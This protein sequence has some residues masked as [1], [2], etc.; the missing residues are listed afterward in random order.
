M[1]LTFDL[2]T[3]KKYTV[4]ENLKETDWWK[5]HASTFVPALVIV[6]NK[7][8]HFDF[9]DL[10]LCSNDLETAYSARVYIGEILT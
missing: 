3:L 1:T 10:D 4:L 7:K 2:M 8:F 9:C 6:E 5:F